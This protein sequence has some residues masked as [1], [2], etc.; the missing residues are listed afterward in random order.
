M[1]RFCA[2]LEPIFQLPAG[3]AVATC[4]YERAWLS[5]EPR[6]FHR[7]NASV[8]KSASIESC[9]AEMLAIITRASAT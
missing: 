6:W 9:T 1:F 7:T 8:E 5:L 2:D 4:A 3:Y